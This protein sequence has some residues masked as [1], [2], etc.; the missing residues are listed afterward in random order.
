VRPHLR[1]LLAL[2]AAAAP[3]TAQTVDGRVLDR[4]TDRPLTGATV[5]LITGS[6]VLASTSTDSVGLF[7]ITATEAGLYRLS[8]RREGRPLTVSR[9]FS[10]DAHDTTHVELRVLAGAVRLEPVVAVA[11]ARRLPVTL[12]GFYDRAERNRGGRFIT[13]PVI[14]ERRASRTTD[15]LRN[16]AGFSFGSNRRGGTSV[17]S[18]GCE[19]TLW[20][21]G[22]QVPLN[23]MDL[24]DIVQPQDIEG[25]EIYSGPA[26]LPAD[27]M[28]RGG[29]NCG[30]VL[31]W[32]KYQN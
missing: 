29:F 13:R 9:E 19:P 2:T 1:V 31:V 27:F 14:E 23:G 22:L 7:L 12:A 4:G 5:E 15:L 11:E 32:T 28:R 26:S 8:V 3:L 16:M 20:V 21:D 17:R 30:A 6:T 18:R 24:D 25:I 10:M